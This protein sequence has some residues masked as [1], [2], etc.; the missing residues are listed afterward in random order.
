VNDLLEPDAVE[1][2]V[3]R[4]LAIRAEDMAPGDG[5]ASADRPVVVPFVVTGGGRRRSPWALRVAVAAAAVTILA[6][7]GIALDIRDDDDSVV[8]QAPE[9]DPSEQPFA[10]PTTGWPTTTAPPSTDLPDPGLGYFEN[11][12][13]GQHYAGLWYPG[14]TR[15]NIVP[16]AEQL[17]LADGR[18]AYFGSLIPDAGDMWQLWI[19]YDDGVVELQASGMDRDELVAAADRVA[20]IPGERRLEIIPLPGYEAK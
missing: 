18:T 14:W 19:M 2:R 10:T 20:W 5:A 16:D 8:S 7:G 6:A 12:A 9:P 1:A 13:T 17:T 4:A 11:A 3:R 15:D